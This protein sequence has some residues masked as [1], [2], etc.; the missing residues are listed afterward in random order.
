MSLMD[1]MA[2]ACAECDQ[3]PTFVRVHTSTSPSRTR[4]HPRAHT[5][6]VFTC[7]RVFRSRTSLHNVRAGC[8]ALRAS[9]SSALGDIA[10]L[11]VDFVILSPARPIQPS[12]EPR[13]AHL[14]RAHRHARPHTHIPCHSGATRCLAE[15]A[16][17]SD[18]AM[19]SVAAS[20]KHER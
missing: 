1:T 20:L 6:V 8:A 9:V 4:V 15:V 14:P 7:L 10:A 11:S 18:A 16:L 17:G 12:Y 5:S 13:R 19:L 2:A 3:Q